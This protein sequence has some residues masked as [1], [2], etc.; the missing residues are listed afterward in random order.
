MSL[1]RQFS[2]SHI[3]M[4]SQWVTGVWLDESHL[5]EGEQGCVGLSVLLVVNCHR[6]LILITVDNGL[7]MEQTE[8]GFNMFATG[9][10]FDEI[11][12]ITSEA[13]SAIMFFSDNNMK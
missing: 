6:R 7:A 13:S 4:V 10:K 12:L 2:Y 8:S 1:I 3:D 11:Q 9:L 5:L